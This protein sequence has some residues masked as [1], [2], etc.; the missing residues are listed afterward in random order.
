M[1]KA[2]YLSWAQ[3]ACEKEKQREWDEARA[4]WKKAQ[5]HAITG[6]QNENWAWARSVFCNVR[7]HQQSR[8]M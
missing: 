3:Q 8:R 6:S 1:S 7:H 4:L 5:S 2:D